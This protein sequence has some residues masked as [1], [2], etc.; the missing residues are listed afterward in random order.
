MYITPS[1]KVMTKYIRWITKSSIIPMILS[2]L[3]GVAYLIMAYGHAHGQV[4]VIDEGLYLYKGLLFAAGDYR[5]FQDFGPLTNHMPLSFL[6]PGWIQ[7]FFGPGIRTGRYFAI[8]LGL[9]MLLG[10]WLVTRRLAGRWWAVIAIW[11]VTLNPA[12]IKIY[13]QAT[14]QVLVACMLIWVLVFVVGNDRK[15]WQILMGVVLS[16]LLLMTRIN[17][18]P[19]LIL[20]LVYVFWNSGRRTGLL[21]SVV[22]LAIVIIAH[23][24]YWPEILKIWAK[25][26]PVSITPFLDLYRI[27]SSAIP[28]W[29][30]EISLNHR[31]SSLSGG[32]RLHLVSIIG[33]L[34]MFLTLAIRRKF[35]SPHS[36]HRIA[37]FLVS[38]YGVLLLFHGAASLGLNY[39]VYCFRPYLAFFSPVGL[40][41]LA[42][43]GREI[44]QFRNGT[45]AAIQLIILASI[46]FLI[47]L[48]PIG[49]LSESLLK[50]HVPRVAGFSF[51]PGTIEL[52]VLLGNKLDWDFENLQKTGGIILWLLVILVPLLTQTVSYLFKRNKLGSYP[53]T[54]LL[55]GITAFLVLQMSIASVVFGNLYRD[56][57]CGKDVITA[58]E[59]VGSYLAEKIPENSRVFWGVGRSPV[60]MLYLP[61][62]ETFPSQLNGDYTFMLEGDSQ[63]L[64]R[65]GYWDKPSAMN[66]FNIADYVLF[67]VRNYPYASE[68][69]FFED[70][71]DE[72]V[73]TPPTNPCNLD[74]SIMIFKRE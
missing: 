54:N 71:Y 21:A 69:G 24:F 2:L 34:G 61:T 26:V 12:L 1:Q 22:G 7:L 49:E 32:I 45:T 64:L 53:S 47:G 42:L 66:W 60:P 3:G 14:S 9:F 59:D 68:A 48:P 44:G 18:A 15:I 29:D 51:L 11:A 4:S 41:I 73:R 67:E 8:L 6:V 31:I 72:I 74:S 43:W 70:Q 23:A 16:S 17:M 25:W 5:P 62:R 57:D 30:H 35:L 58:N 65:Y 19:V 39:C 36:N 38:L 10:L 40:I 52:Q 55:T 13:S 20:V 56:Y 33:F 50:T 63:E 46:P 27:P 37:W 28:Y